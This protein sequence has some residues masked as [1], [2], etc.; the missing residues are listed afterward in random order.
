MNLFFLGFRNIF[1]L[2]KKSRARLLL[3]TLSKIAKFSPHH[4][5]HPEVTAFL[6]G[7]LFLTFWRVCD[8]IS[9]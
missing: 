8:A 3:T 9:E 2:K 6:S 4:D 5:S 1:D 7:N